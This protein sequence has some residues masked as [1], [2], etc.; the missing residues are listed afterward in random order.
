[1]QSD[2]S[3]L[4]RVTNHPE[5]DDYPIWYPTGKSLLMISERSGSFV[6]FPDGSSLIG[7]ALDL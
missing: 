7:K 2:G 1:M 6:F 3:H 5:Q 4:V